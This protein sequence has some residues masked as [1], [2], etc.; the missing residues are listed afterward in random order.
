MFFYLNYDIWDDCK[1]KT[2]WLVFFGVFQRKRFSNQWQMGS[3]LSTW[4]GKSGVVFA[5]EK[6]VL[7]SRDIFI[8]TGEPCSLPSY[9]G[10]IS[11]VI[12]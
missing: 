9:Q 4:F 7:C 12:M 3:Y 2:R 10:W 11:M 5:R 6:L 1:I 8:C